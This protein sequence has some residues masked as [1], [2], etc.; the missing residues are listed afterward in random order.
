MLYKCNCF[1]SNQTEVCEWMQ[2]LQT[3]PSL[4]LCRWWRLSWWSESEHPTNRCA[5]PER[6]NPQ[7]WR[8]RCQGRWRRWCSCS[9]DYRCPLLLSQ[10]DGRTAGTDVTL[11]ET[12]RHPSWLGPKRS[13]IKP[14]I[15]SLWKRFP[16]GK[17]L[18]CQ[19]AMK[20]HWLGMSNWNITSGENKSINYKKGWY[21]GV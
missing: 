15:R 18:K 17:E 10:S 16:R 11:E 20:M 9:M 4:F 21:I 3:P 14:D 1:Y 19:Q 7:P 8:C 6:R 2:Y 5:S 13:Q 12:Q